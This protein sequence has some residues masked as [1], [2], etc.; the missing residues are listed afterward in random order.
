MKSRCN[1]CGLH[2]RDEDMNCTC[3]KVSFVKD[4]FKYLP[5][6]KK[7]DHYEA[8]RGTIYGIHTYA[9]KRRVENYNDIE[10]YIRVDGKVLNTCPYYKRKWWH[11]WAI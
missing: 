5:L 2:G 11:I 8:R 1:N 6:L 9:T 3:R 4:V 7:I 10:F